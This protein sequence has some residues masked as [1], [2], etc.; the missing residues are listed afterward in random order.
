MR[1]HLLTTTSSHAAPKNQQAYKTLH[2]DGVAFY[3]Q[4]ICFTFS[5]I[6]TESIFNSKRFK[7]L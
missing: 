1:S 7:Y 2:S 5:D 4:Q 6:F 3:N